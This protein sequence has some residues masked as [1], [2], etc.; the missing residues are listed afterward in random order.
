[1]LP[2]WLLLYNL[3]YFLSSGS[4][5]NKMNTRR[6]DVE[7]CRK[8]AGNGPVCPAVGGR[9][10][11]RDRKM[12]IV[13]FFHPCPLG[14]WFCFYKNF[15]RIGAYTYGRLWR[16]LSSAQVYSMTSTGIHSAES[17]T[18]NMTMPKIS[19]AVLVTKKIISKSSSW[20]DVFSLLVI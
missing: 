11:H 8:H 3:K 6:R 4:A 5:G 20:R 12:R 7:I 10:F 17:W 2:N 9:F 15:H 1:M 13:N 14:R 16:I 18:I 19:A